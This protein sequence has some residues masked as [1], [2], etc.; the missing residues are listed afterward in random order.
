MT[1][2]FPGMVK[3]WGLGFMI[4]D[5]ARRRPAAR[6]AASPG[7]GLANTYF[8]IDQKKGVGGVYITQILPFVDTKSLPLFFAFKSAV[9]G[10]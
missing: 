4:N 7:P 3:K 9:Y 1:P 10:K 5:A 6:P 8:W 2:V